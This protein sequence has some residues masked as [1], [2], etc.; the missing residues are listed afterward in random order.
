[1][2]FFSLKK[3]FLRNGFIDIVGIPVTE[4]GKINNKLLGLVTFRDIDF[5][6]KE[7]W[8]STP[9]KQV[10]TPIED[11]V[12]ANA[13]LTLKDAYI[14]LQRSKKGTKKRS[15]KFLE[16]SDFKFTLSNLSV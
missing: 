6:N 12:T 13:D 10:M 3:Y 7:Q 9:I 1:M 5:I 15:T 2:F 8:S 4:N 16:D 11:L 14:I